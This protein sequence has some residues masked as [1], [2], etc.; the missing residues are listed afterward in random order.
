MTMQELLDTINDNYGKSHMWESDLAK[1]LGISNNAAGYLVRE[2][3]YYRHK[4]IRQVS[5]NEFKNKPYAK[6]IQPKL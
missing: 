2:A 3:G 4:Q 6:Y 1:L 5:V